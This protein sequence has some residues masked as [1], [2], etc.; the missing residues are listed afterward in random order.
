M[1]KLCPVCRGRIYEGHTIAVLSYPLDSL[2]DSGSYDISDFF[3]NEIIVH[4]DCLNLTKQDK[5]TMV[6]KDV[7]GKIKDMYKTLRGMG[8][9]ITE[10]DVQKFVLSKHKL[11]CEALIKEYFVERN[12]L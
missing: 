9:D 6:N 8:E 1:I 5:M 7:K 10:E 3:R 4:F 11:D 2:S 12:K